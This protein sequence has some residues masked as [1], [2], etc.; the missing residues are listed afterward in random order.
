M[1]T[2]ATLKIGQDLVVGVRNS[3]EVPCW[4]SWLFEKRYVKNAMWVFAA[5][6]RL[7]K[8]LNRLPDI[9]DS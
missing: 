2:M 1:T 7:T 9:V 5:E 3:Q 4:A 8:G 6:N